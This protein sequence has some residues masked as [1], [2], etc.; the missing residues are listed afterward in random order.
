[1]DGRD[2]ARMSSQM[3]AFLDRAGGLWAKGALNGKV[4]RDFSCLEG[5]PVRRL[6]PRHAQVPP[7]PICASVAG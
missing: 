6:R 4:G 1:M 5:H 2:F 3:A 7:M